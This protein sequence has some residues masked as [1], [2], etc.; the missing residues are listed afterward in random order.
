MLRCLLA[1]GL[2]MIL[3]VSPAAAQDTGTELDQLMGGFEIED[4]PKPPKKNEP[5]SGLDEVLGGFDDKPARPSAQPDPVDGVLGGFDE[6]ESQSEAEPAKLDKALEGFPD[7]SAPAKAPDGKARAVRPM[8]PEWLDLSGELTLL[9]IYNPAHNAPEPGSADHRGLSALQAKLR[10]QADMDLPKG[11]KARIAGYGL[12]DLAYAIKGRDDFTQ[13]QL[14]SL[15]S[16]AE[17]TEAW[18]RGGLASWLDIKIGRQIVVWGKS[19]NLRVTDVLNPLDTRVPGLTDIEDLRLPVFMTRLDAYSGSWNL[20]GYVIHEPR[21]N[22]TPPY[23]SDFY[24]GGSSPPPPEDKP[25]WSL[26]NQELALSLSGTFTGMDLALYG[27]YI[28]SDLGHL[29]Y[30]PTGLLRRYEKLYM[31]GAAANLAMGSWLIKSELAHFNGLEF[32]NDPG[33]SYDRSDF[34]LGLEYSGFSDTTISLEWSLSWLWNFQE[35]LAA[36]PDVARQDDHRWA[37]RF[38]RSFMHEELELT[39]L[40]A[41]LAPDFQ[42]GG[43]IR[44]QLDYDWGQGL[45]IKGGVVFYLGGDRPPYTVVGDNHRLFLEFE[46]SF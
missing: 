3:L 19:D 38:T 37:L 23:G 34:M 29:E 32:A 42:G 33:A 46:Y 28:F 10:L 12:H 27:A 39:V 11:W 2:A 21:S 1:A 15:E 41:V 36:A 7:Q 40:A 35:Q 24:P 16:E 18:L 13:E 20:S 45:H 44:S 5:G 6:P 4:T 25:S 43:Y 9:S 22:K 8:L 26:E 14:D 31:A 17:L 30:T